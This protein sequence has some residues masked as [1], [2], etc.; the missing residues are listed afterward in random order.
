[1]IWFTNKVIKFYMETQAKVTRSWR[2]R[3]DSHKFILIAVNSGAQSRKKKLM[4]RHF[5]SSV[6]LLSSTPQHIICPHTHIDQQL[7]R[8]HPA[9]AGGAQHIDLSLFWHINSNLAPSHCEWTLP[10]T[11]LTLGYLLL[12]FA[13]PVCTL[14]QWQLGVSERCFCLADSLGLCAW[15]PNQECKLCYISIWRSA[16]P[17]RGPWHCD[18]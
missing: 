4:E 12:L 15:S 7:P 17:L 16:L 13:V 1:M 8:L 14:I 18:K 11:A 10:P 3:P 9:L 6:C 5:T 2:E